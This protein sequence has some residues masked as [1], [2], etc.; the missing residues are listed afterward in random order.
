MPR[1]DDLASVLVLGSGPIVIGQAGEFDYSGT[2][3]CRVLREEGL[4]VVLV[5]SNPR[6]DHDRSRRRR[7]HLRRATHR[8]LGPRRHRRRATRRAARHARWSDRAQPGDRAGRGRRARRVRRGA[9][10]RRHRGDPHRRGPGTLPPRH[11]GGRPRVPPAPSTSAPWRRRSRPPS[12]S[13]TRSCCGPRSPSVGRVAVS[14]TTRADLRDRIA[15]GLADSPVHEVLVEESVLG[16]KEY[17]LEVMRDRN[18]NCV[19]VC[20]IE[21]VDAMGVPHR[22]LDH[23]RPPR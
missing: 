17:E 21:N 1:R 12:S 8:R 11:D 16:W 13:A 23:R 4:R 22:R 10:G 19:I 15:R 5:N 14:R 9:A 2:Q 6:D 18:D 7:R 20:S 3:A